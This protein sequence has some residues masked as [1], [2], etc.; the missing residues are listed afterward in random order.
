MSTVRDENWMRYALELAK[1]AWGNTHPNPM[2]GAVLVSNGEIVSEGF[3]AKAGQLHAERNALKNLSKDTPNLP[4]ATLYVTL[5][6]CSTHGKTP[7]CTD[8]IVE[9]SIK[10][11]VIGALDPNPSHA[12][13]GIDILRTEGIEVVQGVLEKECTDLNLIFNH[14]ITQ[15]APL[16]ALKT[17]STLDGYIA[18][19][20][21]SSKWITGP[22]ARNKGMIWRKYFPAIAVGA[23]TVLSDDPNLTARLGDETIAPSRLIFDRSLQTKTVLSSAKVFNDSFRNRT[24]IVTSETHEDESLKPY[25]DR[26][27]G[28]C[29]LPFANHGFPTD[30]FYD[31]CLEHDIYGVYVEGGATLS[32]AMLNARAADYLMCFQAP[33]IMADEHAKSMFVG[34]SPSDVNRLIEL[35]NPIYE[36]LG[37]DLLTRGHIKY[38]SV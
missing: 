4:E 27:C 33:K 38:P 14:W 21:G 2:V 28:I 31:W 10:R 30:S 11:V 15:K 25:S 12:G 7:P 24:F 17:A 37:E 29:R 8:I 13:R 3:H 16:I 22:E 18:T 6:P 20:N 36:P 32:S 19:A 1:K 35:S 23:K 26:G 34:C 9:K 5:E